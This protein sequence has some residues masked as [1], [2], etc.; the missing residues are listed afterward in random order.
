MFHNSYT[1]HVNKT[2]G[3]KNGGEKHEHKANSINNLILS[4][5]LPF[6]VKTDT[7]FIVHNAF[8]TIP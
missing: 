8:F 2:E 4:P 6:H 7:D 3:S 1:S 5:S